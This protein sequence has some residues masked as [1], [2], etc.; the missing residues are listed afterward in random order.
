MIPST[1]S[2]WTPA[3]FRSLAAIGGTSPESADTVSLS[4]ATRVSL[5]P[6]P[7]PRAIPASQAPGRG[8][9]RVFP[10]SL[11]KITHLALQLDSDVTGAIRRN[12]FAAW[13]KLFKAM[14][15]DVEFT[16]VLENDRDRG[17][18][19]KLLDSLQVENQA[20]IHLIVAPDL[21]ITMWSRDQM[22]GL[23][24]GQ[25][26]S[27]LGQTTMRPHGDDELLPPRIAQR[28]PGVTLDPDKRLVTDG[29]DEVSNGRETF[30]GYNSL[31]LTAEKLYREE[32]QPAGPFSPFER[33]LT[34]STPPGGERY[35]MP[36]FRYEPNPYKT[37]DPGIPDEAYWLDRAR[38]L[39]E[40]KYGRPVTV[41][42]A[43]D[44]QTPEPEAPA[45][46]HIDMGLTPIG[47]DVVLVG[48]PRL[49]IDTLNRL[50]P[51]EY[52][53]HN[54]LL[55]RSLETRGED[56][57]GSLIRENSVNNPL[58][59][60]QFDYNAE[61]V[62]HKGYRVLRLPYLQ[63]PPD[64]SWITYNNCLQENY[65]RP[66]GSQ[67]RRVFLP[68]Y[69]LPALDDQAAEVYRSLGFEVIP[70]E[71]PALTAW[72]GAIRCVSNILGRQPS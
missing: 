11:G 40:E 67:V 54:E 61:A 29:G 3:A 70:L 66:D 49:A 41:V 58:L 63:G 51:E 62:E 47:D 6:A 52:A 2:N 14:D 69:G 35:C 32:L 46:F 30:L 57:L 13:S 50:S 10:D 37:A 7:A 38:T 26:T 42:G 9:T 12:V 28:T 23:K 36:D 4:H 31:Y 65:T 71:L 53:R 34:T 8:T 39:F 17:E 16:I 20:R 18:V 21:D 48:D 68:T 60:H 24:A 5:S 22:I 27:L 56:H 59:Q 19:S 33:T 72:R 55:N 25:G 43:D 45:T 1:L 64:V 44:P 15:P